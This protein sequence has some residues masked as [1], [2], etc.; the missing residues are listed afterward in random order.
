MRPRVAFALALLALALTAAAC[1]TR[2]VPVPV[3]VTPKF[4][5][6][7]RPECPALA[8]T[9]AA[10]LHDRAWR[11]LQ[12][13]DLRNAERELGLALKVAPRSFRGL[14]GGVL[15]AQ[16][17]AKGALARFDRALQG[18]AN[19][20]SALVGKGLAL[21]ALD[22]EPEALAAFEAALTADA[23][24]IDVSRR[25]EVLKFR[26]VE[27]GLAAARE[28]AREGRLDE[29]AAAYES[30]I[31]SSPD[32]AFLY[33]ELAGVERRKGAEDRA[34]EHL[35]K[36]VS[37]IRPCRIARA[38]RRAPKREV[39]PSG[40]LAAYRD[41]LAIDRSAVEAAGQSPSP[42]ARREDAREYRAS[43]T[44]P[45]GTRGDLAALIGVRLGRL[46][47]G[48]R[49]RDQSVIT[50]VRGNWAEV[51]IVATAR[52][53]VLEPFE[54]HTFQPR[55]VIRR[56]DL[57]QAVSPLIAGAAQAARL[58]QWQS[59]TVRTSD[60]SSSHLAYPAVSLAVAA[61]VMTLG[62]DDASSRLPSSAAQRPSTRSSE[63]TRWRGRRAVMR[64]A[65]TPANQLTRF[66]CSS[67]R[68]GSSS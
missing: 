59:E 39:M 3:V 40:A 45:Q 7:L 33:R 66:A 37:S 60:L 8:S 50:D 13:G 19:Y 9:D 57:A 11:F 21:A 54:N 23:T 63:S 44:A 15:L 6:F 47:Q 18:Q 58:K 32:S 24:L 27:R 2:V 17:D 12:A 62:P 22:R 65:F 10:L 51:W 64:R 30:A 20:P 29:A 31:A 4:P 43:E 42:G 41:S 14:S 49:V 68:H 25:V 53:G 48:M 16:S 61:G 38:N 5:D 56:I 26:V 55:T 46:V 28:A 36:A 1:A 67:F 52:A 35:R 34:L